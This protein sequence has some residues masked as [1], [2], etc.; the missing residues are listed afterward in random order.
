MTTITQVISTLPTAPDPATMTKT[1][2]NTTAA[3]FVLA[4]KA[5]VPELNTWAGQVNTVKSEINTAVTNA[6]TAETN[7]ELAEV[8]AETAATLAQDWATKTNGAVAGGEFSAK[9]HAQSALTAPGTQA[10]ST[11][12][13]AIA[14]G[15]K[16]FT[17]QTGKAYSTGQAMVAASD[18]N[19]SVDY[20]WGSI[21]SYN[22]G[23]GALVLAVTEI[24]G[25]G[26]HADWTLSLSP[27]PAAAV[28][29][30]SSV[31]RSARTSN[32]ILAES[33]RGT[34][35]DITSGTFTQTFTAAATLASGWCC[36]YRNSGTGDVTLDPDAAEQIDGLASFIMYP[37]ECRLIQCTGTAFT[38]VVLSPFFKTFT[39]TGTFTKPPGYTCFSGLIWSGGSSGERNNN[40]GAVSHAGGGGG[41]GDFNILAS[42]MAATETITIGAGGAAVTTVDVG[43]IG[44]TSSIGSLVACY[45]GTTYRTGG[46]VLSGA[47]FDPSTLGFFYTNYE[48]AESANGAIGS[49]WGGGS[50]SANASADA[51]ASLYGGGGGGCV[52]A[53]GVLR[54]P[55]VSTFGGNGGAASVAGNGTDG[56]APGGGGGATQTGTQSGAGARGEVRIWGMA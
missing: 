8:N 25:S 17:I 36:Y 32:T 31:V 22:S 50:A 15:S 37:N 2:F 18:A 34:L 14:T 13:L 45:G 9:Y 21:T 29:T 48:G 19:P 28:P 56:T 4:Q 12:S 11:T 39:A 1:V 10:T 47:T 33:D 54:N 35:I 38:S 49:F 20:M 26:T 55:G 53:A 27:S 5:E 43:N 40:T 6:Q 51:K 41:C 46:S 52:S 30:V 16:S 23:T 24:G 7:A 3:A 42:S 44:G